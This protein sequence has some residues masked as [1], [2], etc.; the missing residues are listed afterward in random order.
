MKCLLGYTMLF[1][2]FVIIPIIGYI[3]EGWRAVRG[4]YV[5]VFGALMVCLYTF[6]A[7]YLIYAY[8]VCAR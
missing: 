7:G 4:F 8:C 6:I 3:K 1:A 5:G 2:P